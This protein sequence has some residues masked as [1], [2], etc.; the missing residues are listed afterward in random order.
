MCGLQ[1]HFGCAAL[2]MGLQ[3]TTRTQAPAVAGLETG[4]VKLWPRRAQVIADIFRI[5]QKFGCH[6]GADRMAALI[7]GTGIARAIPK[8]PG[9]RFPRAWGKNTPQNVYAVLFLHDASLQVFCDLAEHFDILF[10]DPV[11]AKPAIR[12]S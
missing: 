9:Q 12:S 8:E 3:K 2:I 6:H 1:M 10:I 4:K 7:L 5:G 11:F